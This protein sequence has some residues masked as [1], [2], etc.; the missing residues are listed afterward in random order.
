MKSLLLFIAF[1]IAVAVSGSS[2]RFSLKS[3]DCEARRNRDERRT[4]TT[5]DLV[6][7]G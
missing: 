6:Y 1:L 7:E 4:I 5:H 3:W 2:T